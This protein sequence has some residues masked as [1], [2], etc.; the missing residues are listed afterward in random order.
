MTVVTIILIVAFLYGAIVG[1]MFGGWL[2]QSRA[3]RLLLFMPAIVPAAW[4]YPIFPELL[5]FDAVPPE[6]GLIIGITAA[7]LLTGLLLLHLSD[8]HRYDRPWKILMRYGWAPVPVALI[9]GYW[10][11]ALAGP[12]IALAAAI[13]RIAKFRAVLLPWDKEP[14][15]DSSGRVLVPGQYMLDGW[16]A[17]WEMAKGGVTVL[18][19][20]MPPLI[21]VW[22]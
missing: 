12:A 4:T 2:G 9:T 15:T 1:R 19:W 17:Y 16:A 18:A 7:A 10:P 8:G 11:V 5:W 14:V 6:H 21:A 13:C 20:A 3:M 22:G